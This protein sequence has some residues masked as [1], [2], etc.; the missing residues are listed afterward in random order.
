VRLLRDPGPSSNPTRTPAGR[1]GADLPDLPISRP[2]LWWYGGKWRIA[3]WIISHLPPHDA[4]CEPY[5]G[6]ASVLLRKPPARL[7]TFNDLHGRLV[8]FFTI[9]RERPDELTRAIELTPYARAEFQLAHQA[10]ADPLEDAR[11]FYVLANQG[12]SGAASGRTRSG[13]RTRRDPS[14]RSDWAR[15][16]TAAHLGSIAHRL[17][18]VQIE[19]ADAFA[20]IA[21]YDTPATL[22]YVDPP[23]VRATRSAGSAGRYAHDLSDADHRA[24]AKLLHQVE[25]MVVLSGYPSRLYEQL[26][27]GWQRVDHQAHDEAAKPRVES[28]WRNPAASRRCQE[29]NASRPR[30]GTLA[31]SEETAS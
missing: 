23:Y 25:G 22:H 27:A 16:V 28:L 20:V 24:L 30:P 1:R 6:A 2:A 10:T 21:R 13:W 29:T 8:N 31:H 14:R 19:C 9:L 17:K 12:R 11:R 5:G 7:E 15:E 4:Y 18:H 26:Y 3:P